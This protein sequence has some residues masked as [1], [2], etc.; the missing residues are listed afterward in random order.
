MALRALGKMTYQAAN[1]LALC[2][3]NVKCNTSYLCSMLRKLFFLAPLFFL[4][5]EDTVPQQIPNVFVDEYVYLNNPSSQPIN[6]I[7]GWIYNPG[8]YKG[9][10]IYRRYNNNDGN[11]WVAYERACPEHY[12]R[13]CGQMDVIEDTYLECT[14]D[15]TRFLLFDGSLIEGSSSYPVLTYRVDYLGDRLHITNR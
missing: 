11:D 4:G 15:D 12:N 10:V 13:E 9:L 7:G 14:C 5:C 1:R 3:Q 2:E 8:G 6:F